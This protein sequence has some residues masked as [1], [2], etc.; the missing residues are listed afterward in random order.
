MAMNRRIVLWI[1]LGNLAALLA[2]TLI[3]PHLMIAPGPLMEGHR[4]LTTDC[5]ACHS[6]WRGSSPEKCISCHKPEE[7]GRTDTKGK[8]ITDA[9]TKVA[10]H[11]NLLEQDCVACHS[12][13]R[14]VMPYR[15]IRTFSHGLLAKSVQEG[16]VNCHARPDDNLHRK[17]GDDCGQCHSQE[18]WKPATFSHASL[19]PAQLKQC[20]GCHQAPTDKLHQ[21]IK[22]SC[23]ECHSQEKWKP[24]TFDHDKY[25]RFDRHH[26]TECSTCHPRDDYKQYTCYGCHEHSREK[27][28][29]EHVKEG[30][31]D[32]EKCVECH[33]SGDEH[34]IRYE[35]RGEGGRRGGKEEDDDD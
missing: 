15:S 1:L 24:A 12:D 14:G 27:I 35:G 19:N 11:H 9:K 29:A 23:G 13:H 6:P 10:F 3:Y 4:E 8:R 21:G 33:R 28:R 20:E 17:L 2:L 31:N 34:D 22:G 26:E 25:F 32:Y 30:I 5:W 7:I 16:C 18:K